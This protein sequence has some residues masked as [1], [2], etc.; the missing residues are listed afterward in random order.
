MRVL[1]AGATGFVGRNLVPAMLGSGEDVRCLVRTPGAPAARGL[2]AAGAEL[3]AGDVAS[4]RDLAAPFEAVEVAYFLVHMMGGADGQGSYERTEVASARRFARAAR[5]AGVERVVYLGGLGALPSSPHLR[6][7]HAT[8]R[9]LADEGPPLV[10]MRAGMAIGAGSESYV[11]ARSAVERLPVVPDNAWLH[12]ESQPIG[13]RDLVA[14]LRLAAD[15]EIGRPG[16]VELG[17]PDVLSHLDMLDAI[18]R[19]LG[20]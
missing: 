8:G 10:Y 3:V 9:A 2:A 15:P 13:I 14:Y 20:R 7:R 16:E 17:G 12:T 6:S 4:R 18:A 11:L 5:R 19:S 1:I